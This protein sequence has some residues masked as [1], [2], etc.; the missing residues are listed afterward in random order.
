MPQFAPNR[1][2]R[3]RGRQVMVENQ[4]EPGEYRFQLVVVGTNGIESDPAELV[5]T[6]RG[7]RP[8]RPTPIP[9]PIPQPDDLVIRPFPFPRP[10]RPIR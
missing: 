4:L 8:F 3:S 7:R 1:P 5:V 2:V 10:G 6:V 9:I